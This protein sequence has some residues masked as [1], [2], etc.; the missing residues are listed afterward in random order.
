[1]IVRLEEKIRTLDGT[2]LQDMDKNS[3]KMMELTAGMVMVEALLRPHASEERLSGMDK[4]KR[5]ELARKIHGG[6]EEIELA[7]EEVALIKEL[8]GVKNFPVLIVGQMFGILE[9]KK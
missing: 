4:L 7:V 5:F 9:G 1:M 8:V 2:P 3:G 6:R